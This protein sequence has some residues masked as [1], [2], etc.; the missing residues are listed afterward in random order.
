MKHLAWSGAVWAG[1]ALLALGVA[2]ARA[3]ETKG[4]S[5]AS[6]SSRQGGSASTAPQ[7]QPGAKSGTTPST[8]GAKG[9]G[10]GG[11]ST[12]ARPGEVSGAATGDGSA[13]G[14]EQQHL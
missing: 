1:A 10:M 2:S 3:E 13:I 5:P 11:T 8:E 12:G 9:S 4:R 14:S 6:D 7:D